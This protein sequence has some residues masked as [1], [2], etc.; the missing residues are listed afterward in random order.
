MDLSN[1]KFVEFKYLKN[2]IYNII[3]HTI[4]VIEIVTWYLW[5]AGFGC[6]YVSCRPLVS[7]LQILNVHF[8]LHEISTLI[9]VD[10]S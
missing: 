5:P 10:I 2:Q 9:L 1:L 8:F 7:M 6:A 3:G 4:I